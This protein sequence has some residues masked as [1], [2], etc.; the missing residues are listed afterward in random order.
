MTT[1]L[2]TRPRGGNLVLTRRVGES[3][4]FDLGGG[5]SIELTLVHL[6]LG[7]A[8]LAIRAPLAVRILRNEILTREAGD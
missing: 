4:T 7:K 6:G 5:E 3:I 8:G 1:T 2:A